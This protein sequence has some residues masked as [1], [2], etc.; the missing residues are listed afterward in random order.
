MHHQFQ[1]LLERLERLQDIERA[2]E[3]DPMGKKMLEV[4]EGYVS[5]GMYSKAEECISL[6]LASVDQSPQGEKIVEEAL[7]ILNGKNGVPA[8]EEKNH[9][10]GAFRTVGANGKHPGVKVAIVLPFD[11]KNRSHE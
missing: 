4:V 6:I 9:P 5:L 11:I 1:V 3:Q 8:G 2:R 10:L 7:L